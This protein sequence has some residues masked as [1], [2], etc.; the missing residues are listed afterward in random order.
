MLV[1]RVDWLAGVE[2]PT[3]S[4]TRRALV[5]DDSLTARALHRT[6]LEAGGYT[7]HTVAGARQGLEQMRHTTYDV[8]VCDIGMDDVDGVEFT[9]LVRADPALRHTPIL[10]VSALEDG[11]ERQ[12]GMA[13][14]ADGFLSK[15]E[16]IGGR[17]VSDV[18]AVLARR[19]RAA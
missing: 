15:R 8:V 9:T 19:R 17:L 1:L 2:M 7:V 11:E 18:A 14:G 3:S 10:L 4:A 13:A 12:R 16:C 5:V 6:S